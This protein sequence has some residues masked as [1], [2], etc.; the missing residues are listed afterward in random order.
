MAFWFY[1]ETSN[2]Q[3]WD[4]FKLM[5]LFKNSAMS[6][7]TYKPRNALFPCLFFL[8]NFFFVNGLI[9][10]NGNYSWIIFL[11]V[12]RFDPWFLFLSFILFWRLFKVKNV[13]NKQFCKFNVLKLCKFKFFWWVGEKDEKS[14]QIEM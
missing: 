13:K 1:T 9:F 3:P 11:Y 4:I 8:P 2:T 5:A 10:F 12:W 14:F 6:L 7:I